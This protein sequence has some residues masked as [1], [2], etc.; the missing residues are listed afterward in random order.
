MPD[1]KQKTLVDAF[2]QPIEL[3]WD[4][5]LR[6]ELIRRPL[7]TPTGPD[8]PM[9]GAL[10]TVTGTVNG[11]ALYLFSE[12]TAQRVADEWGSRPVTPGGAVTAGSVTEIMNLVQSN[13]NYLVSQLG[14]AVITKVGKVFHCGSSGMT[15]NETWT[16]AY[17]L[18]SAANVSMIQDPD[19]VSVY[20][21][22]TGAGERTSNDPKEVEERAK[23]STPKSF[24]TGLSPTAV[25]NAAPPMPVKGVDEFQEFDR[26][27]VG[28]LKTRH[29]IIADKQG[30][31]RAVFRTKD[32]GSTNVVFADSDGRMR[33]AMALSSKGVARVMFIDRY[34]RRAWVTPPR[35]GPSAEIK[36]RAMRAG[37][38]RVSLHSNIAD[39]ETSPEDALARSFLSEDDEE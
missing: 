39:S 23:V 17:Q 34:G 13:V 33:A 6:S 16:A 36:A 37:Q 8:G 35:Q 32:D 1:E 9:L 5:Q 26:V 10:L 2:V 15:G 7:D 27:A 14:E 31:S 30:R 12:P 4:S 20:V 25:S 18:A 38:Q 24:G 29:L 19:E 22:V 11:F 28:D 21:D 3:T